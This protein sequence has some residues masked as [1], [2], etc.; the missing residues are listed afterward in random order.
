MPLAFHLRTPDLKPFSGSLARNTGELPVW[1]EVAGGE[2][3]AFVEGKLSGWD[4]TELT[5]APPLSP[6]RILIGPGLLG[7]DR[8]S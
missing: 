2:N 6:P 5:A 3:D 4:Q 1:Q 8:S 7:L